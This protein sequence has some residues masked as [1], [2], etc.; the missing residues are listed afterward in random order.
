MNVEA[1]RRTIRRRI[2][3]MSA[4]GTLYA[5][6][7]IIMHLLGRETSEFA[8]DFLLG[9]VA[10]L[11]TCF[12]LLVPRYTRALRDEQALRRLWNREHDERMRAIKARAGVPMLL[13]TSLAMIAAALLVASWN[14]TAAVTLLIAATA[15]LVASIAVKYICL[16]RM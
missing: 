14:M 6:A 13:Y 15:Q 3:V 2:I 4:L 10:A 11:V 1:Y 16:R 8:A 12:A 5:A 7:M 9:A